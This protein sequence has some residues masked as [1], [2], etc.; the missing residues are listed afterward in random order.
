VRTLGELTALPR[1]DIVRRFGAE[2]LALWQRASGGAPRPLHTVAPPQTFGADMEFEQEIETLEPLL[3]ILRRFLDRL[4]L[5]LQSAQL[6]AAEL[7]LMLRL[8]DD[9][10]HTLHLRLPEPTADVEILF[11]T[12]HTHL[13]SLRTATGIVAVQLRLTPAR[14]L[15]RQQGLFETGLRDPHGFAETL[16]RVSALVGS[17]RIGTPQL[18]DTHRSDAVKLIAPLAVIPPPVESPVHA[19]LGRPL[20]RFRPPLPARVELT[21]GRATYLWTEQVHGEISSQRGPWPSSGEWWQADRA[22]ARHEW[23]I[24]LVE[25]GLYRLLRIGEAWFIEGEYD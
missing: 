4:A 17:D 1:D 11:R 23:D 18:E 21:D 7:E 13:E 9:T 25:G 15:V 16:A 3:F 10:R 20:R 22:W 2:G 19:V 14:P 24:E 6:V 12:L 5:E 8:E